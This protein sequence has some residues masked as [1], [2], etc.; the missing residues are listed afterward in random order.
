MPA[1]GVMRI[2]Y[3]A[4]VVSYLDDELF[5]VVEQLGAGVVLVKL[6]LV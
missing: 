4:R 3:C 2:C 5:A 1:P 6:H